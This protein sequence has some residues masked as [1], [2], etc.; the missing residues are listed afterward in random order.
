MPRWTAAILSLLV[1]VLVLCL[2]FG[3][4]WWSSELV[5][6]K[7]PSY[8]ERFSAYLQQYNQWA[9]SHDL[10]S[11]G[12]SQDT[13][14]SREESELAGKA[15]LPA[16]QISFTL[17]GGLVLVLA[18]FVLGLLEVGAFRTKLHLAASERNNTRLLQ[19]LPGITTNF[20]RYIVVR[21]GIGL[22]TG[23]LAGLFCWVVGL[24]FAFIWGLINFL[25][26]YIPTLGSIIGVAPP[27]LFSLL[28]FGDPLHILIVL[29]GVGGIQL[30]MG[31]YIDPLV[32]GKY[33][34]L[35]PLV[36]L[37]SV[38]FWGRLRRPDR[39]PSDN[40]HRHRLPAVRAH[41]LD[42]DLPGGN[43]GCRAVGGTPG[44]LQGERK[45]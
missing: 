43:R 1:L 30:I 9:R 4:L 21:T 44:G 15:L 31:N 39:S 5:A 40:F 33:L 36:V 27:V 6:E 37:L 17:I 25:L 20:Q 26:N 19:A 7:W 3:A 42:R 2:F 45:G 14:G 16:F 12:Q 18:F 11:I 28:Q 22:L 41:P 32:Q 23:I 38:T 34:S 8:S 29:G 13:G 24:D 10:P 35:S